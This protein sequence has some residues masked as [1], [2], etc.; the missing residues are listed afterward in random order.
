MRNSGKLI[1]GTDST[2]TLLPCMLTNPPS[3]KASP[4]GKLTFTSLDANHTPKI[5][6]RQQL[7]P[8]HCS[9]VITRLNLYGSW[10]VLV[11]IV[12]IPLHPI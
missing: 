11:Q 12:V 9:L 3:F 1:A 10:S 8:N 6:L 4:S 5:P 7:F 2:V